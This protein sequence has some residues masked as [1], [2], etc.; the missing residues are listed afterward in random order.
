MGIF[1]TLNN[2]MLDATAKRTNSM[3]I[4]STG[5]ALSIAL[6]ALCLPAIS[7]LSTTRVGQVGVDARDKK[8]LPS[9][10]AGSKK[11]V[12][13]RVGRQSQPGSAMQSK[14]LRDLM[15][16]FVRIPAGEFL[17]GSQSAGNDE[18]PVHRVRISNPFEMGKYEL[19]QGEWEALMGSNPSD[20]K[21]TTFPIDN[22]S[23]EDVQAFIKRLNALDNSYIYRLPTEAEWEYACRAGST[24]DYAANL[25]EIGWYSNNSDFKVHSVGQKQPN[26]WGLY[27]MHGNVSEWC[28]DFFDFAYYGNSPS[29][30]PQGPPS[31]G[32][33]VIRN[34]DW[35]LSEFYSRSSSRSGFPPGNRYQ[36]LG[37]RL[38]R[39]RSS[40]K[41]RVG[42]GEPAS[43]NASRNKVSH[44]S[45]EILI[46]R[47]DMDCQVSIDG[48]Y[49]AA[50]D[51]AQ[52]KV[53]RVNAG[54]H[55]IKAT[56]PGG[57][58][59]W[60]KTVQVPRSQRVTVAIE[61][62]EKQAEAEEAARVEEERKKAEAIEAARREDQRRKAANSEED[63]RRKDA[64]EAAR[65]EEERRTAQIDRSLRD[66]FMVIPAGDFMMG[67]GNSNFDDAKPVHRVRFT[68]SLEMG[69]YEVTQELWYAVMGTNPSYF[70]G[71]NLPVERVSWEDVQQF[72]G[73]LNARSDGYAYRLPTEPEWEYASRAGRTGTYVGVNLG[74]LAWYANNSGKRQQNADETWKTERGNY[75]QKMQDN[76]CQTHSVGQ[77]QPNA[78]G[79]YDMLGNVWEWCQDWY[80]A[81][82]YAESPAVD[83]RGPASGTLRVIRG[84]A[85][86]SLSMACQS[87]P[88]GRIEAFARNRDIGF[89]LVRTPIKLNKE[90]AATYYKKGE[91]FFKEGQFGA[92]AEAYAQATKL[93]PYN[94]LY[95]RNLGASLLNL[96]RFDDSVNAWE[97]ATQLD[98]NDA[99]GHIGLGRAFTLSKKYDKA[100]QEL[101]Y[102]LRLDSNGFA[103]H[104]AMW[105]YHDDLKDNTKALADA[106]RLVSID[107]R[108][109]RARHHL[110]ATYSKLGRHQDCIDTF[111]EAIR[112]QPAFYGFYT[113]I[114]SSYLEMGKKD[115]A[116]R[117]ADSLQQ[118]SPEWAKRLHDQINDF[119]RTPR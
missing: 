67:L 24:G 46:L 35:G 94:A 29:I 27:D 2:P 116:T 14:A 95:F 64:E 96:K 1:A 5:A 106:E 111:Q 79:L 3:T 112:L 41:G 43:A 89:R 17:M 91:G 93:D 9:N 86:L 92:A 30:D 20:F 25:D 7:E 22:V 16:T 110:G 60:T 63:K 13:R 39:T 28:Q 100:F 34:G 49:V 114:V 77:K 53:L 59:V 118:V 47:A 103:A 69:K 97:R 38:L 104:E 84:G 11:P 98:V 83:P 19:T 15:K 78:W 74:E 48:E 88:R 6:I 113:W 107:P 73:R 36:R 61:L 71:T 66:G 82:Y 109:S 26:A 76:E 51:E 102:A 99:Q 81:K 68:K 56:S 33:R 4:A 12:K 18:S 55:I 75:V 72:I 85:F 115:D 105:A 117:V 50:L 101:E 52:T 31:G 57:R 8:K 45:D 62:K 87:T 21:G 70:K 23:W 42:V 80:A 58:Y 54:E 10:V 32:L 119:K 65:I 37:F 40:I 108:S 44:A 90:E